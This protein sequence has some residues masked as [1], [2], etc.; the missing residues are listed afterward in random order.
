MSLPAAVARGVAAP[1][2]FTRRFPVVDAVVLTAVPAVL[3]VVFLLPRAAVQPLIF[4]YTDPTPLS[5]YASH[6]VHLSQM[7]LLVNLTGYLLLAPAGYLLA[8]LTGRRRTFLGT[9]VNLHLSVPVALSVLNLLFVRPRVTFGYSGLAMGLLALL[10]LEL[11]EYTRTHV[12]PTLDWG[13]AAVLFT[14]EVT[15]IAVALVPSA[16]ALRWVAVAAGLITAGYVA[17]IA[18]SAYRGTAPVSAPATEPGYLELSVVAVVL[19]VAFP[20]VAFPAQPASDG[21]VLNLYTHLLGFCLPFT[22]GY[23]AQPTFRTAWLR[24]A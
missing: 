20:F 12:V 6:F 1:L 11:F 19:L 3:F 9:F 22:V 21:T 18:A 13:D 16:P 2:A 4:S 15:L 17:H 7:H 23:V 14:F 10:G 8:R 5:A 24:S